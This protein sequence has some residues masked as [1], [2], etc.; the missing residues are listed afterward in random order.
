MSPK[1]LIIDDSEDDIEMISIFLKKSG[2]VNVLTAINGEDGV[3]SAK[4]NKPDIV[5][6][7]TNLSGMNGFETCERIKAIEGAKPKVIICT[8][9]ID[10][11]DAGR[12][13]LVKADGYC[14]KTMDC[15]SLFEAIKRLG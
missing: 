2:Y 6:T 15:K 8:G 7:D 3:E 13:R 5:I 11:I 9:L 10:A 1:I 14:V 12:A 4:L